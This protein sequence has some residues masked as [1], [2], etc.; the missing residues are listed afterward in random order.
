MRRGTAEIEALLGIL[1]LMSV[2][3]LV[4]GA[5]ELGEARL[6]VGSDATIAA[7]RDA[8]LASPP[9]YADNS[10]LTPVTG[11]ASIRPGLPNRTHVPETSSAVDVGISGLPRMGVSSEAAVPS[12]AWTFRGNPVGDSDH[13]RTQSWFETYV[14]ESHMELIDPLGLDEPWHP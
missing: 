4:R 8:T 1:V 6:D 3:L 2:L 5:R 9:L 10:R 12:P 11:Y 14:D 7:F 13:A